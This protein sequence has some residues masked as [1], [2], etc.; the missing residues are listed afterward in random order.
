[1]CRGTRGE[2]L[3]WDGSSRWEGV[4]HRRQQRRVWLQKRRVQGLLS[5]SMIISKVLMFIFKALSGQAPSYITD[6]LTS[7]STTRPLRSSNLGLL[8]V[9]QSKL[10]SRGD[11]LLLLQ[12]LDQGYSIRNPKGP[13]AKFPFSPGSGT[14]TVKIQKHNSDK[15]VQTMHK[16]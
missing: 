1:M 2:G 3:A 14:V 4:R 15:N 11:A 10:K 7:Y 6:L 12:P 16:R 9:P 13:L 5:T 8:A